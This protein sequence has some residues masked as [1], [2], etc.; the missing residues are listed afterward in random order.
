MRRLLAVALSGTL[1]VACGGPTTSTPAVPD[2][3]RHVQALADSYLNAWFDRNPEQATIYGVPGRR[4]DRLN[5]N[6]LP[7][8]AQWQQREDEFLRQAKTIDPTAI[9][10]PRLRATYAIVREA[11]DA[12][13][14]SRICRSELWNVSEMT[15]WHTALGYV[16]TIQPV[17][18]DQARSQALARFAA[19]PAY[20]DTEIANAR[21]GLK[22]GYSA[23]QGNVRIVIDEIRTL[24]SAPLA[25][26]PFDS[27]AARD[28][29]SAF[30]TQFE[31]LITQQ[32]NPA[33]RRYLAFL[34]REY[35]PA[36]RTAIAVSANP[37]GIACYEA[38]I[39]AYSSLP[40]SPRQVHEI[41]QREMERIT[42]E[43]TEIAERDFGTSDLPGLLSKVRIDQ[44]YLFKNREELLSYSRAALA[45]ADAAAP[46]WFGLRPQSA[47]RLEPY[48]PFR[49]KSGPSEY[50]PPAEDGSHPGLYYVSAYLAE[51]KSRVT[52]ESTAFHE[53][54]PGHHLQVALALERKDIHPIG[55]YVFNSGY[56][57]GWAL[58]AEQLADE[59]HLYSSDLDRLGMLGSQA[60]RAAR[61]VVDTGIHSKGWTRQQAIAYMRTHTAENLDSIAPEIDRY[62]ILPG[63]ATSYMLGMLEIRAARDEAEKQMGRGFDIRAFHDRVLEDGSLPLTFL[64]DKIKAWAS[65]A[66]S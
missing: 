16:V 35:L 6:S 49:E 15:G 41:G 52:A 12:S 40:K 20:I 4:H 47:V 13:I 51:R 9:E 60:F 22:R 66:A 55:R 39:R 25:S 28:G 24:A 21:E 8:L 57:E 38:S 17:G 7:A 37:D 30:R 18:T 63:Q 50:N 64:R 46:A 3:D 19:L 1:A 10:N 53:T 2:A 14:G 65:A 29:S 54:I 31:A 44:R 58:Y 5:D 23:P 61:L 32:V 59:M 34:E 43:M 56:V 62:I 42:R 33:I 11:L 48:P 27:P 36:A 26:S 45:R